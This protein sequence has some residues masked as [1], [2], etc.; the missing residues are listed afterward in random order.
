MSTRQENVSEY[1]TS[2]F[3][4]TIVLFSLNNRFSDVAA[5]DRMVSGFED[6]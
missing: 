5:L 6:R 3:K 4:D 1:R 2:L